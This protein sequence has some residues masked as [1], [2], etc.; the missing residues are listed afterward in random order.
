MVTM[1]P[2]AFPGATLLDAEEDFFSLS[3]HYQQSSFL[4]PYSC[5]K[6]KKIFADFIFCAFVLICDNKDFQAQTRCLLC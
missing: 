5:Q 4:Q 2:N 1:P 3:I 6:Q